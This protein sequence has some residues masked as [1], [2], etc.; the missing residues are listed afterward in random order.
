VLLLWYRT[1]TSLAGIRLK[2]V[3]IYLKIEVRSWFS[4]LLKQ[5]TKVSAGSH[6]LECLSGLRWGL[7]VNSER[8]K[9]P[10]HRDERRGYRA[11]QV[12]SALHP[13]SGAW[14]FFMD[15][16][17]R[18]PREMTPAVFRVIRL[19]RWKSAQDP[20]TAVRSDALKA[21]LRAWPKRDLG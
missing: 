1:S 21:H 15:E 8:R 13:D 5:A 18:L 3:A 19:E 16:I 4:G 7:R 14:A 12:A 10:D 20:I 6:E 11:I 17:V 9:D 2:Q